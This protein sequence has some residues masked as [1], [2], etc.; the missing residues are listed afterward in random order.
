MTQIKSPEDMKGS[1]DKK[2][3]PTKRRDIIK[4][5]L[6]IFL[7]VLLVLTFFSNTIMNKSL[8]QISTERTSSGKLTERI[9]GSGMVESNQSYGVTVDGN[10][11]VDAVMVKT[12]KEVEKGDV[13]FTVGTG[14]S[15]ELTAAEDA[16]A[17][18][19]L[20]YQKAMLT[21]PADYSEE[22]QAIK[23]ARDDLASAIAKRDNAIA[24]QGGVQAAK[25]NYN[26]NKSQLN[27]YTKLET[28]LTAVISAIDTD[29]YAGAPAEYT[30]ELISLQNTY[31][32]AE[33]AYSSAKSFYIMLLSGGSSDDYSGNNDNKND[34]SDTDVIH[35]RAIEPTSELTE[36]V[37]SA[38][39]I[40]TAKADMEAKEVEM[41]IAKDNYDNT[42]Y[43]LRNEYAAQLADAESNID[44]YTAQINEYESNNM[45]SEMT[46]D[47][48]EEDV[49]A[50]QRALE[51]LITA[52]NKTM[53]DDDN[54]GKITNLDIEAK[55]KEIERAEK[56]VEKLRKENETTEI[57][58]KHSGVVSAVNIKAG[59]ETIPDTELITIDIA[60]EGYTVK[61]TVDAEKT[62][63]I[64]KGTAA[65][66]VN[67]WSGGIEAVLTDIK[68][69]TT[70]GSKNRILVFSVTGD[71]DSGSYIDLSIP[72]GSGNYDAIV[73]KSAVYEDKDGKFVLTVISKSSP[74][75]NRY[76]AQKVPVEIQASD[77]VSSAVSGNIRNGDYV[78]TA[79]SKP[80]SAGDQVKMKDE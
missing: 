30:G 67:N 41:N 13:L 11:T 70:A 31:E 25:D 47:D 28:K 73:P 59:D 22:N 12:G 2:Y 43:N 71:V 18:L 33:M 69:D 64:K 61:I 15:E 63:K 55:K 24:N 1:K 8:S 3:S 40:E 54:Q 49:K 5:I 68:N 35:R 6:I 7:A 75:G 65:E 60:E 79:A 57:K 56:Q 38:E 76:Y 53:K 72:C 14:E 32:D 45:G 23:N 44:W 39:E 9:R 16:L 21:P 78:I 62:K 52:L 34:M 58:S 27:Y 17:A 46:I 48:L 20:E 74:L 66:V 37:V 77:E 10:K 51:D 50:K 80:V 19:K 4:T 29:S 26:N 36:P 42:K